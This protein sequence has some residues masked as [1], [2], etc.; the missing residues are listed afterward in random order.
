MID[1]R[2]VL[3]ERVCQILEETEYRDSLNTVWRYQKRKLAYDIADRFLDL[4]L[5]DED[6]RKEISAYLRDYLDEDTRTLEEMK[7]EVQTEDS[8]P[9]YVLRERQ[10]EVYNA[11]IT[12]APL[13]DE[14]KNRIT[15]AVR[16]FVDA[17]MYDTMLRECIVTALYDI[18]GKANGDAVMQRAIALVNAKTD[19]KIRE[20]SVP[21]NIIPFNQG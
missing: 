4:K 21:D 17:G 18:G 10:T 14:W 2:E 3:V 8:K 20:R 11:L 5:T 1:K 19:K 16:W 13:D 9:S 12:D 15:D 6:I 7:Q